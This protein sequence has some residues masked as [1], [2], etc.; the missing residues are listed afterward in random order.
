MKHQYPPWAHVAAE[1]FNTRPSVVESLW[2][3]HKDHWSLGP[4]TDEARK[5]L[6]DLGDLTPL[7]LKVAQAA[8]VLRI[9]YI[10]GQL[11]DIKKLADKRLASDAG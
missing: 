4:K 2:M 6:T 1:Q 11:N 9:A 8:E 5:Y 10:D 7:G 3:V